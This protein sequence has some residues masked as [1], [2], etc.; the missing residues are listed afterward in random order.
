MTTEANGT[1]SP[2]DDAV[3]RATAVIESR[4]P[5]K[6]DENCWDHVAIRDIIAVVLYALHI[7]DGQHVDTLPWTSVLW[8][9]RDDV[10]V[11]ELVEDNVAGAAQA[12][13]GPAEGPEEQVFAHWRWLNRTWDPSAPILPDNQP[14]VSWD[15]L[16]QSRRSDAHTAG[17]GPK[18]RLTSMTRGIGNGLPDPAIEVCT[19]WAAGAV[20]RVL[21][22]EHNGL[23]VHQRVRVTDGESAGQGGYVQDTGWTVDDEARQVTGPVCYLVDLD[24]AE[25]AK[26]ID[27]QHL[28]PATDHRWPRRPNGTLKDG[29]L[30]GLRTP[31]PPRPSCADDLENLLARASNPEAVPENLQ[32]TIRNAHSHHH[33]GVRWLASPRPH[34]ATVRITMHWYQLTERYASEGRADLW[35][36]IVTKHLRDNDPIHLL[37]LTEQDAKALAEQHTGQ[38]F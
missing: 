15:E 26:Q 5:E 22:A 27:A 25:G 16:F 28:E 20:E 32:Q 8:W 34:R 35:E 12:L 24:D 2:W 7:R 3:R 9:L 6:M 33:I 31:Y 11:I 29:P 18:P 4:T 1:A 38:T 14:A 10:R 23:A 13:T 19:H 36:V 21:G 37:T 17:T 30:P